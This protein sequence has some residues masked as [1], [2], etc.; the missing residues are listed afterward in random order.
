MKYSVEA[1]LTNKITKDTIPKTEIIECQNR[2]G[3]AIRFRR[4]HSTK[5]KINITNIEKV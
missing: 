4:S 1:Y 2:N 3:A 5:Y